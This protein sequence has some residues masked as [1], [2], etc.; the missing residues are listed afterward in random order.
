MRMRWTAAGLFEA[1][2]QFRKIIG[3]RDLVNLAVVVE[4]EVSRSLPSPPPAAATEKA[5]ETATV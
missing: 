2:R 4:R 3:Y 1:E 5:L